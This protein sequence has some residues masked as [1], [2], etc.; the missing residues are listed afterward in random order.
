VYQEDDMKKGFPFILCVILLSAGE[1]YAQYYGER[2]LEKSFEQNSL[3]FQPSYISPYGIGSFSLA[4]PGLIDDPFLNLQVNPALFSSDSAGTNHLYLDFRS[5][6]QT[7]NLYQPVYP[8]YSSYAVPQSVIYPYYYVNSRPIIE[9]ILSAAFLTN[10]LPSSLPGLFLG[11]TYQAIMQD[12]KYYTIPFDIYQSYLGYDYRGASIANSSNIPITTISSGQDNMHHSGNLLSL[13][14]GY[15]LSPDLRL[16][17][18][19]GRVFFNEDGSYGNSNYWDNY[20]YG[21]GSSLYYNIESRNQ[22]YSH[23]DLSGGIEYTITPQ[24]TI[25]AT[26]GYLWGTATQN[27]TNRDTSY[28]SYGTNNLSNSSGRTI[29]S[30][31][32]DGKTYYGGVN[33]TTR[34][35]DHQSVTLLYQ[36]NR[37]NV[38]IGLASTVMD[39]SYYTYSYSYD[40]NYSSSLS[41]SAFMERSGGGG[42]LTQTSHRFLVSFSWKLNPASDLTIGGVFNLMDQATSTNEPTTANGHSYYNTTGNAYNSLY[43]DTTSQNKSVQWDF[44]INRWSLDIPVIFNHR[45]S[46]VVSLMLGLDKQIS[47]WKMTDQTLVIYYHNYDS[48]SYNGVTDK[49]NYGELYISPSQDISD[50]N[51][52]FLAGLTVSPAKQFSVRLLMS[53][54]VRASFEGVSVTNFQWWLGVNLYP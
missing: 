44:T 28:Y 27:L 1:T 39:T 15:R 33:L 46:D 49:S 20:Y 3:F 2:S 48:N 35:N 30:W 19:L 12:S 26:G 16:G 17:L 4:T 13:Y 22:Y 40:T 41:N 52:V 9:P 29:E 7:A 24:T 5:Y 25:G 47:E 37:E 54:S 6:R 34:L 42:T 8:I 53:P 11:F 21:S 45:F 18:R 14:A 38:D 23:W 36:Y 10:P 51:T 31:N 50:V 43:Y 32:N